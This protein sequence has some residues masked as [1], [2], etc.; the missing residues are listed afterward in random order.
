MAEWY[1][2]KECAICG[3]GLEKNNSWRLPK[4]LGGGKVPYC[5]RC[6]EKFFRSLSTT[7]GYKLAFF[8]CCANFNV[9]YRPDLLETAEP[10]QEEKGKFGG[11][12]V[13]LRQ[14][15]ARNENEQ[16][17]EFR[18]GI[19][20]ITKA[21]G[22]EFATLEVDDEMLNDAEYK[23]GH[24]HQVQDWGFGPEKRPYSQED[25]DKLDK[26][27]DAL[28]SDRANVSKQ[29]EIAIRNICV[30]KLEQ[31][32][33]IYAGEYTEAKK[34]EDIIKAEME[35]EQLRKKDELPQDRVRLDDI[36]LACERAGL[37]GKTYDELV[38]IFA[39]KMFHTKYGYT[40]DAADQMLLYIVNAT[41][42]NEGYA[43]LDRLPDDFAIQD[44]MGEFAEEP[45][46]TEQK[47]YQE[48]QIAPLHMQPKGGD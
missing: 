23:D 9:P 21:F 35:G 33:A 27:Y 13:A 14:N 36:V 26:L 17:L 1:G 7:V 25:F 38:D 46:E 15:Q 37:T 20:D 28:V 4:R 32:Y 19:T 11:Y 12:L 22:G 47:I 8:L 31:Q 30:M 34:L 3:I 43:E 18:D 45:D 2:A 24:I 5:S 6:M 48:L 39:K 40:R 29:A 44:P 10:F 16:C 42:V 41:R